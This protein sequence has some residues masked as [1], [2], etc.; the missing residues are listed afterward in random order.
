MELVYVKLGGSLLTDKARPVS[1]NYSALESAACIIKKS[2]EAGVKLV[3]GNGGGSFAHH[4]V[5]KHRDKDFR[6]LL[7]LCQRS[8]RLLNRIVVDYLVEN[9]IRAT[10][11]QTSSVV[12]Y[13]EIAQELKVFSNSIKKLVENDIV[14]VVYG[15]CIPKPGGLIIVSTEHVFRLLAREIRPSRIV[16][17]TD[18]DGVY[19]CDPKKCSNPV[20]VRRITRENLNDVL[21][22][23]KSSSGGDATGGM[24]EKVRTAS[25]LAFELGTK[26][27]IT[28]GLNEESALQAI[29]G[30]DP[31]K[32]TIIT[33]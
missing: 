29:L 19:T 22:L 9:G 27:V 13:N 11:V 7:V 5:L 25:D 28:S 2:I 1:L 8:T 18:V 23:L 14:P 6:D 31:E 24:Y 17:L 26:V 3:L 21:L 10:S 20:L 32:A 15:E 4:V 16:L 33:P 30:R 12:Y